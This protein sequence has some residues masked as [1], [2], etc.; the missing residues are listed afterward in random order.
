MSKKVVR[1]LSIDGGGI[2]GL[3]PAIMLDEIEKRTARIEIEAA[4]NENREPDVQPDENRQD[5]NGKFIPTSELFDLIAG[6]STGGILALGLTKPNVTV[7]PS[8]RQPAY[9][10]QALAALYREKGGEIFPLSTYYKLRSRI[11][12]VNKVPSVAEFFDE[13]YPSEGLKG[14]LEECFGKTRLRKALTHVLV[15]SYDMKCGRPR[16]FK[17]RK[18][19]ECDQDNHRMADVAHATAAAPT[20]FEPFEECCELF[21]HPLVDGGIFANNPAMCAFAEA[22]KQC[23]GAEI[24]LVSLGT[25]QLTRRLEYEEAKNW[26]IIGWAE[27]LLRIILDGASDTVNYQLKGLLPESGSERAYYR[28][29]PRLTKGKDDMDDASATNLSALENVARKFIKEHTD[30]LNTLCHRLHEEW[31]KRKDEKDS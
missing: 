25:G 23:P 12:F 27:P 26:G 31:R 3:I 30:E 14:V 16:F 7:P 17:S 6:T 10:A 29:Q 9:T 15:P 1:I 8:E 28:F 18:A 11:P 2:R 22:K 21:G 13:K 24:L 5:E 19:T 20:Y 4:E